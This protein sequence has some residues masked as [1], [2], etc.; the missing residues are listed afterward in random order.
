MLRKNMIGLLVFYSFSAFAFD[1][2]DYAT[3]YRATRDAYDK[4]ANEVKLAS[5]PYKAARDAYKTATHNYIKELGNG[6]DELEKSVLTTRKRVC[7]FSSNVDDRSADK[8]KFNDV[9][10]N[11]SPYDDLLPDKDENAIILAEQAARKEYFDALRELEGAGKSK[12]SAVQAY[13]K[14]TNEYVQSLSVPMD[15]TLIK[16]TEILNKK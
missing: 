7:I 3:T 4:A 8:V 10:V 2:E 6:K 12:A 16:R 15:M 5:G 11:S 13:K 14:A 9:D 1:L